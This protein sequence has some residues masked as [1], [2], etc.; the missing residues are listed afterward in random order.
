MILRFSGNTHIGTFTGAT[1]PLAIAP[2]LDFARRFLRGVLPC[3][4]RGGYVGYN[5]KENGNYYIVGYI[6]GLYWGYVSQTRP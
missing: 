2:L 6:L 4:V 5:G 1:D 3:Q